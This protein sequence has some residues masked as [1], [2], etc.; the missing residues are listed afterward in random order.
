MFLQAIH[1][2]TGVNMF[3]LKKDKKPKKKREEEEEEDEGCP[4]C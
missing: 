2:I 1:N 3:N 4:F